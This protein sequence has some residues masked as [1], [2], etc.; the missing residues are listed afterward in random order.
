M[1]FNLRI[2]VLMTPEK[3]QIILRKRKKKSAPSTGNADKLFLGPSNFKDS[4][5]HNRL[6]SFR[7]SDCACG[8][9]AV[10]LKVATGAMHIIPSC[11]LFGA[12]EFRGAGTP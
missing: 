1:N 9:G 2:F 6:N 3:S 11:A 10:L 5:S 4:L 7:P 8:D 12:P